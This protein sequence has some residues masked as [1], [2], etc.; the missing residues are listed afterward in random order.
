MKVARTHLHLLPKNILHVLNMQADRIEIDLYIRCPI[1]G[2][3]NNNG[4]FRQTSQKQHSLRPHLAQSK[5]Y[6]ICRSG[7][8]WLRMCSKTTNSFPKPLRGS[9]SSSPQPNSL[10]NATGKRALSSNR[11]LRRQNECRI[12]SELME[13]NRTSPIPLLPNRTPHLEHSSQKL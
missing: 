11:R 8:N 12:S 2:A 5:F 1:Y 9:A 10:S 4:T 3:Y 13:T 7:N 6:P